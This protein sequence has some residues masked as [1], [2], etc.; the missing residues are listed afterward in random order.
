MNHEH[1]HHR[2]RRPDHRRHRPG[3]DPPLTT[4]LTAVRLGGRPD[5]PLLVLGPALGTSATA[6]WGPCAR[7]LGRDLQVV[8]WDLP[9]HGT[10]RVDPDAADDPLTVPALAAAVLDLVDTMAQGL[11]RPAFHYA[12]VSVGGAVGLQL[13]LDAPDRLESLTVLGTTARLGDPDSWAERAATVRERGTEALVEMSSGRWFAPGFVE[14]EP[15]R[16]AGLLRSLTDADDEA[17]AAVCGALGGFD[18]RERLGAVTVP[19]LAV[20]GSADVPAPPEEV[21]GLA[22]A[23]PDG[24]AVELPDVAHLAPAEAPEEV[25]RLVREHALGPEQDA[26]GPEAEQLAAAVHAARAAGLT[27]AEVEALVRA[28]LAGEDPP[29]G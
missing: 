21:R 27:A 7:L 18:V 22:E 17:Y 10:N 5:L 23:V 9:G 19:L 13:A 20:G 6:L 11:H 12:G 2:H 26:P 3:S 16:A 8:A 14:R 25:A 4:S 28:A 24:R 1:P 15:D 29:A